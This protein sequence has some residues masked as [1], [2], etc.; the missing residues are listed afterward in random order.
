MACWSRG[1]QYVSYRRKC[2][3][4]FRWTEGG[5]IRRYENYVLGVET[6]LADAKV[7]R[8][9]GKT[10]KDVSGYNPHASVRRFRGVPG[11]FY[12]DHCKAAAAAASQTKAYL[13]V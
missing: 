7:P 4:R 5:Q 12:R 8:S 1:A 6:V 3:A 11:D 9:C 13:R 2:G 10:T